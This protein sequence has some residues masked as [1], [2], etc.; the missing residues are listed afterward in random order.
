MS[1][2]D[3]L[4]EPR[5]EF[6]TGNSAISALFC[7]CGGLLTSGSDGWTCKACGKAASKPSTD[8]TI[9]NCQEER[10]RSVITDQ[11]FRGPKTSETCPECE[12]DEAYYRLQQIRSADESETR[13]FT[14]ARC[15][16]KWRSND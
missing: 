11:F 9:T 4:Q 8:F 12:Y 2:P 13:F 5:Q 16:H 14:C 3:V 1:V 7:D 10:N 6:T 15:E